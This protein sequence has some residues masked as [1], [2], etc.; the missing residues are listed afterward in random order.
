MTRLTLLLSLLSIIKR[1]AGAR[2][3]IKITLDLLPAI[4]LMRIGLSLGINDHVAILW[5]LR[6]V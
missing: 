5:L 2:F 3:E 4:M 1:G 6:D